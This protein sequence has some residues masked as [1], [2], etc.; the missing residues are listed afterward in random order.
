MAVRNLLAMTFGSLSVKR[1]VAIL[2]AIAIAASFFGPLSATNVEAQTPDR[3]SGSPP[4][5][6]G[7]GSTIFPGPGTTAGDI[8]LAMDI[9][10]ADLVSASI[11]TSDPA[12][13]G[14]SD[15]PVGVM[16]SSGDTFGI[17]ASGL[18]VSA[19]DPDTNNSETLSS[20]GFGDED[21][22]VTT[23]LGGLNNANG[24]DM[25]QL[26]LEIVPPDGFTCFTF[27]FEFLSE[28]FPDWVASD[29]NDTFTAQI[30]AAAI[31]IDGSFNVTA[32]G[33]IAFDTNGAVISVLI[34][35]IPPT[36][37]A[38]NVSTYNSASVTLPLFATTT[39][40]NAALPASPCT[41]PTTYDRFPVPWCSIPAGS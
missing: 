19:D 17:L 15:T 20:Q 37:P 28:E 2:L 31:T 8:A 4:P 35:T 26:T 10:G 27:D 39:S 18:A 38:P 23:V 14:I 5:G 41:I 9:S 6:G 11:G 1:S 33:N 36:D 13:T 24:N 34:T 16:P 21:D 40:S 7:S 22:D 3:G 25:V 30:G 29:F 12:G 32:P